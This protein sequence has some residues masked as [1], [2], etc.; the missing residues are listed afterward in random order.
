MLHEK[1]LN[2]AARDQS[3]GLKQ[4]PPEGGFAKLAAIQT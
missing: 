1:E 4:K 3:L 2:L